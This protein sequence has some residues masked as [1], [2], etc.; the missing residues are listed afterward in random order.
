MNGKKHKNNQ[1]TSGKT[2]LYKL[3]ALVALII[4]LSIAGLWLIVL[5]GSK[6]PE[7]AIYMLGAA[8]SA[9]GGRGADIKISRTQVDPGV[10]DDILIEL[11]GEKSPV[12]PIEKESDAP[13]IL[14]YHTH[15][16]EAYT[17]SE[18]Y[19]YTERG[20]QWRTNDN[21]RNIVTVG[22]LLAEELRARGFHVLHDTTDHEPPKLATSYSRSEKTMK[23]YKEEYPSLQMFIDVHRDASGGD[24]AND[25]CMVDGVETARMMFVVGTGKG[26]TG[27]GYGEMPDFESNYALAKALTEYMSERNE[28]LMR[29][30]RVKTGRYNQHISSQCLLVEVGHNMNTLDHALAAIPHLAEAIEAVCGR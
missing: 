21:T 8:Y 28:G 6:S 7:N 25:F 26:A 30:I 11:N 10:S 20:G 18:K 15:T 16:L 22:E 5:S 23:K 24:N 29:D 19:P 12:D 13:T 14:I 2:E 9:G 17:S 3:R 27:S 4:A 1:R